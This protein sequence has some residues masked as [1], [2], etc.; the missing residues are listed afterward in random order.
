MK[1]INIVI[2]ERK[3]KT[4]EVEINNLSR[5]DATPNEQTLADMFENLYLASA[6]MLNPISK[7]IIKRGV[8]K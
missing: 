5:E 7:K 8:S 1:V 3:D 4:F 2:K 6:E